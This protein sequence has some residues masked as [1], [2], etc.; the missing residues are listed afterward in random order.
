MRRVLSP[1]FL[2]Q[3]TMLGQ[4]IKDERLAQ[5]ISQPDFAKRMKISQSRA[6]QI[7]NCPDE[8]GFDVLLKAL[9]TLGFTFTIE[10]KRISHAVN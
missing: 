2:D 8:V 3:K 7:E 1:N 4:L 9:N 10:Y 6:S 5:D